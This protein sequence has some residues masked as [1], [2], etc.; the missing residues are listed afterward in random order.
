MNKMTTVGEI[1]LLDLDVLD[2]AEGG[3]FFIPPLV[4]AFGKGFAAGSGAVGLGHMILDAF[5]II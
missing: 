1:T 2:E 3:A 4:V 5:D